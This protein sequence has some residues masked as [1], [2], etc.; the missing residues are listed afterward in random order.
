MLKLKLKTW[1]VQKGLT[2]TD[3]ANNLG[4]TKQ[5]VSK[6]ESSTV[7]STMIRKYCDL[8]EIKPEQVLLE[9]RKK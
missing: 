8:L 5:Y 1:R 2:Q 9:E 3:A 6:M 7:F 4:V